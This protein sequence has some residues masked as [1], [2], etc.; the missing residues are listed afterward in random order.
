MVE[1][2]DGDGVG[3]IACGPANLIARVHENFLKAISDHEV[4]IHNHHLKHLF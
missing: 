2:P 4:I 3:N 1:F